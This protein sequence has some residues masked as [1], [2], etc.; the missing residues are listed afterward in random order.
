MGSEFLSPDM[1]HDVKEI[2]ITWSS[3]LP[4]RL[5][6]NSRVCFKTY[7]ALKEA[8]KEGRNILKELQLFDFLFLLNVLERERKIFLY[9]DDLGQFFSNN[10]S[11]FHYSMP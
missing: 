8:G 10:N 9:P 5:K 3:G 7:S 11:P 2:S 6:L 1:R 4:K